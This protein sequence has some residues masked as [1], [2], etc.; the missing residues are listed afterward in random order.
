M[1]NLS[2][3][4]RRQAPSWRLRKPVAAED[5][6]LLAKP[7]RQR[8]I[9][10]G[11]GFRWSGAGRSG[12]ARRPFRR[13]SV[14]PGWTDGRLG[15]AGR[16]GTI[17]QPDPRERAGTRQS[18]DSHSGVFPGWLSGDVLDPQARRIERQRQHQ[19]LG[20]ADAGRT[21]RRPYLEGVAEFDWSHDGSRLAYHTPGPGDPLFVSD[22]RPAIRRAGRSSLRLPGFTLTFLCGRPTTAFIYFVQGSLPDKLDIWRIPPTG[23][24]P[25]RITSHN[26]R[27]SYPVFLDRRTLMYLASDADGSGPWLYSMD[28]ERRDSSPADFWSGPVHVAGG[29][30]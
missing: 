21:S 20:G 1:E 24:T 23:G 6:V 5:G 9:S 7:D 28:V 27:V 11:H 16:F 30:R 15:Y 19:R 18:I 4:W 12:V 14:R 3:C 13:V 25:E 22:G 2:C 26:G 8:A 29:Q 17:P 10:D